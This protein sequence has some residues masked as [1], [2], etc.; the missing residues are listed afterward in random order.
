MITRDFSSQHQNDIDFSH[1]HNYLEDCHNKLDRPM[2]ILVVDDEEQLR[3]LLQVS[4]ERE[5]HSVILA[6]NGQQ[7]LEIF[8][9]HK[10]D[11]VLLD[12]M[13]PGMDGFTTCIE[14]RKRTNVPVIM[15]TALNR[16][17]DVINGLALGAD[18]YITKPF[19]FR[20]V[21]VRLQTIMR[22]IDWHQERPQHNVIAYDE[23][24]LNDDSHEVRV[25]DQAVHL[26]NIEYQLLRYLMRRPDRPISKTDLFRNVWGYNPAG[27]TNL[28][29]VAMRRLREKVEC[30][31]S[32][33]RYLLTVRGAGYKFMSHRVDFQM[34]A[35]V[36]E[37]AAR[38]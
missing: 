31:P 14:L 7:A 37:N 1:V 12:V 16:H 29:E 20:E 21:S 3:H 38:V 10:V 4:L 28:V 35:S 11:L 36:P 6:S 25:R 9:K 34:S 2:S 26:T 30:N 24:V 19:T 17:N 8:A 33:P 15:L 22:R 5:G 18:D 27:G 13:M 23:I 32:M